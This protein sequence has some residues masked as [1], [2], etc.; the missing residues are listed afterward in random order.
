MPP[1]QQQQQGQ[2]TDNSFAPIWI[3]ILCGF[4][5]WVLWTQLHTHIVKFIFKIK[6]IEAN[7]TS[8]FTDR[9]TE[10]IHYLNHTNP[11]SVGF[12]ELAALSASVG[13]YLRIPIAII[14]VALAIT[15]YY[16]NILLRFRKKHNMNSLRAQ[17]RVN[18]PH[19]TPIAD[20]DLVAEDIDKGPWAMAL[21][22][23]AYCK[24]HQ[25]LETNHKNESQTNKQNQLLK[26]DVRKTTKLFAMQL[27]HFWNGF[28]GLAAHEK[29][30]FAVFSAKI[31]FDET[32]V[33]KLLDQVNHSAA[34]G[35]LDFT[36]VDIV[37]NKH[38]DS[39]EV[40]KILAKHAYFYSV[41]ATLLD[42]ARN[43]G[44]LP[45]AEFLWL[46]RVDRTLWYV[47]NC[48]GRQTAFVEVA[49]CFAHWIAEKK[50]GRKSVVP[51]VGEGVKALEIA[52]KETKQ[53]TDLVELE[54]A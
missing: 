23:L 35:K 49:G 53:G 25:L 44:V 37:L 50:L 28:D 51:M 7:F 12:K 10:T 3:L 48:V 40:K 22:P 26:L 43:N 2:N 36:G 38:K 52:I 1:Q 54:Q 4:A 8:F 27:G 16:S 21:N 45:T 11:A 46:K 30:L 20:I 18:W 5:G 6:L 17:E 15:L 41:M 31:N 14:L 42:V 13:S 47:L 32:S 29:M 34:K 9:L 24:K 39:L 33:R 19:I